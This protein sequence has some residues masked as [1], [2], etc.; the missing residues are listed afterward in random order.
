MTRRQGKRASPKPSLSAD[1]PS[2]ANRTKPRWKRAFV[3]RD[4]LPV[5]WDDDA[6]IERSAEAIYADLCKQLG[7]PPR[8]DRQVGS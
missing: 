7:L 6:E 8:Q 5:N 2:L 4:L 3:S 1:I